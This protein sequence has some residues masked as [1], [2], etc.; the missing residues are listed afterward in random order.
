M[1][2]R[3][4]HLDPARAVR[5]RGGVTSRF[6]FRLAAFL[7]SLATIALSGTALAAEHQ[8]V[9]VPDKDNLQ[10]VAFWF[11][12]AGGFFE[13]E[14]VELELVI[15]PPAGSKG[16]P[17]IDGL[18]DSGEADAAVMAPPVYLRMVAAKLPIVIVANLFKN[19]G[20]GL[21][22]RREVFE[23]HN[24]SAE[25]PVRDRLAALK[26]ITIGYPPAGFARLRTLLASQGR[27][28]VD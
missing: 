18:L 14:G 15:A 21:V 6:A 26:G 19:D 4:S 1:K 16:T 10:Y 13:R 28:R 9:I 25:A 17:P 8:K 11:A 3:S 22:V 23:A 27:C 12:K 7:V 20:Y 5:L 24:V 2:A